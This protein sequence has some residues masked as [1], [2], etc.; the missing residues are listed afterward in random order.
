LH[1]DGRRVTV[2]IHP[3]EDISPVLL[4]KIITKELKITVEEFL[5]KIR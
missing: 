1:E 2:P 5:E 3:R 4:H